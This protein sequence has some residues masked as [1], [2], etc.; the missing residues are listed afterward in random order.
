[1]RAAGGHRWRRWCSRVAFLLPAC[2]AVVAATALP[3]S[4]HAVLE[5]SYPAAE[6][7]LRARPVVVDLTF[8][9]TV[10]AASDALH[11]YDDHLQPVATSVTTHPGGRGDEIAADLPADLAAGTYTVTWRVTSADTHVVSGSFEFSIGHRTTVSG[12]PP[13]VQQDSVTLAAS[14][15]MRGLGYIGLVAGPGALI[16]ALWLWPA[17]L[18]RRRVR[19]VLSG[20]GLLVAVATLLGFAVQGA[21]AAGVPLSRALTSSA[22]HLGVDGRF[23]R[24]GLDRL[25]LLV[26]LAELAVMYRE[27][28][29]QLRM[30]ASVTGVALAATWSYAGHA[31]TGSLVPLTFIADLVHVSAM[32]TWLGG[33]L[34]L[35]TGVLPQAGEDAHAVVSRFSE[36]ALAAVTLIVATGVFASWRNVRHWGALTGTS[37]GVILLIKICVV[38]VAIGIAMIS[39]RLAARPLATDQSIGRLRRTVVAEAGFAVVVLGLTAAL[40]GKAQAYEVYAPPFTQSATDGGIVV[41]VH[42]D[43][44][45]V[46]TAQLVVSTRRVDGGVQ[47]ISQITG[48][49]TELDPPIGPLQIRFRSAGPGREIAT[50]SFPDQ[51]SWQVLLD[52]RT[53]AIDEIEVAATVPI[54]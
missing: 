15:L 13:T 22:L 30:F 9:E 44:T 51:G 11:V 34:L 39:R 27:R 20:G 38:A 52:V 32:A 48:T 28:L 40:T 35:C 49:L 3:A 31:G 14:G 21:L 24:A 5:H 6:A 36:W 45:T 41:T 7:V 47:Q 18:A 54:R 17:G 23:G 50:V 2:G 29:R 26:V 43:R 33:L 12:G 8:D 1:M 16:V 53:S 46:G 37:Y 10:L 4:A 19:R 25:A 42:L